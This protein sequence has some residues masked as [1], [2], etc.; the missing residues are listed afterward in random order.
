MDF[1][2]LF[3]YVPFGYS[4]SCKDPEETGHKNNVFKDIKEFYFAFW[5]LN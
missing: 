2:G 5:K 3:F 4:D 1:I